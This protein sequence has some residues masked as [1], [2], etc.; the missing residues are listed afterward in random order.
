MVIRVCVQYVMYHVV[1]MFFLALSLPVDKTTR[2]C[3]I[4]I[5][6]M[7]QMCDEYIEN[8]ISRKR[9]NIISL[10]LRANYKQR[11]KH[12]F[13]LYGYLVR[14]ASENLV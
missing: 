9:Q 4:I 2:S 12:I 1:I 6:R 7:L 5:F 14:L 3:S 13:F 10:F 11:S 8:N